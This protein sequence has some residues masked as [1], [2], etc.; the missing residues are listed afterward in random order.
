MGRSL[1]TRTTRIESEKP[2]Q[3]CL[4]S[5]ACRRFTLYSTDRPDRGPAEMRCIEIVERSVDFDVQDNQRLEQH[6][7]SVYLWHGFSR[8]CAARG[9]TE[10]AVGPLQKFHSVAAD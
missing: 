3:F 1:R 7:P 10:M 9:P 6:E 8:D 4:L 5:E 2:H